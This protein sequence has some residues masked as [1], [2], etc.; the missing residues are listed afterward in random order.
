MLSVDLWD[1]SSPAWVAIAIAVHGE[2]V[3]GVCAVGEASVRG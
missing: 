3:R 1:M 2:L